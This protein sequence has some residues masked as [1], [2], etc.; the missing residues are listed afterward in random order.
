M[1]PCLSSGQVR[2]T[3]ARPCRAMYRCADCRATGHPPHD[4]TVATRTT[5]THQGSTPAVH[6]Y[7]SKSAMAAPALRVERGMDLFV[8]ASGIVIGTCWPLLFVLD[9]GFARLVAWSLDRN[10]TDQHRPSGQLHGRLRTESFTGRERRCTTLCEYGC[11]CGGDGRSGGGCGGTWVPGLT[12][13]WLVRHRLSGC[14]RAAHRA[15]P[16][17]ADAP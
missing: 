11:G 2:V 5:T 6:A 3:G 12:R 10:R 13:A 8:T 4:E 7:P 17:C 9:C 1:R 16:G 14:R 15:P